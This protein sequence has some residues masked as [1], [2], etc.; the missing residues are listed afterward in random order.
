MINVI[1]EQSNLLSLNATIAA[2]RAGDAGKGFAVVASEVKNLANQTAKATEEI[3]TQIS[4][5]EDKTNNAVQSIR[6]I[7][8]TISKIDHISSIISST[9]NEQGKAT[10]DIAK[11]IN[12]AATTVYEVSVNSEAVKA[13][14]KESN[15]SAGEILTNCTDLAK[16]SITLNEEVKAFLET[17]QK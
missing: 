9:V 8:E 11:N 6:S 13:V 3:S 14:I 16:L 5:I 12:T 1:A 10:Q 4:S 17:I 2:A 7:N 15:A